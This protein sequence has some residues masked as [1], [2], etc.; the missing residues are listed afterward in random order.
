MEQI[1]H[2]GNTDS[3]FQNSGTNPGLL[4]AM[5]VVARGTNALCWWH[6]GSLVGF[7]SFV[8]LLPDHEAAVVC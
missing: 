6:Q 5:P 3:E 1:L 4:S 7:T 2:I 8:A